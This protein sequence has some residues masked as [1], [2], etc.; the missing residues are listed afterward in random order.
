MRNPLNKALWSIG[1]V[2]LGGGLGLLGYLLQDRIGTT[3]AGILAVIGLAF[4]P[5]FLF[6]FL[7]ALTSAIGYSRLMSGKGFIARWHVSA[8][9]W[10]RFRAYDKIRAEEHLTLRNDIRI[11]KKTPPQGVD[12]IVGRHSIIVD[13]SYHHISGKPVAGRGINWINAPVDPECIEF[14]K[15]YSRGKSGTLDLTLRVPV[16]AAARAEGVK[17]WEFYI[18]KAKA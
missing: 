13:G 7:W 1:L 6:T 15:T 10:D 14:P 9:D 11:R 12:V 3:A 4:V 2:V 16:P 18:P 17:V 8:G 5:I